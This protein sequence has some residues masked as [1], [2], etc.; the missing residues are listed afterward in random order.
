MLER[1]GIWQGL[2]DSEGNDV[3]LFLKCI[4]LKSAHEGLETWLGRHGLVAVKNADFSCR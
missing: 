2:E 3:M 4:F 1:I